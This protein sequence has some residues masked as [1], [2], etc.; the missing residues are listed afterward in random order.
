MYQA[1][2]LSS[3][4]S[5]LFPHPPVQT[6][7]APNFA[8]T[9]FTNLVTLLGVI[10]ISESRDSPAGA[11]AGSYP[12]ISRLLEKKPSRRQPAAHVP[13]ASGMGLYTMPA[14]AAPLRANPTQ[15]VQHSPFFSVNSLVPSIGSINSVISSKPGE[16]SFSLLS[17][18]STSSSAR[19]LRLDLASSRRPEIGD[20]AG[21]LRVPTVYGGLS[22]WQT[23]SSSATTSLKRISL[24][25]WCT[26]SSCTSPSAM[27]NMESSRLVSFVSSFWEW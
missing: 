10:M 17:S 5:T 2:P 26:R 9:C 21:I 23:T 16:P 12:D 1:F 14:S 8:Q 24:N 18:S 7:S 25:R 3:M 11:T 13:P 15:I 27:V 20:S 6:R 19:A 22:T 4:V